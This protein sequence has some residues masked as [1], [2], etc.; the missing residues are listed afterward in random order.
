MPL[1]FDTDREVITSSV[2][3]CWQ[4]RLDR[5]RLCLMPNT[6]EVGELWVSKPLADELAGREGVSVEGGAMELPFDAAG[7]LDQARLFPHSVRG[8]RGTG[9]KSA[10]A[11]PRPDELADAETGWTRSKFPGRGEVLKTPERGWETGACCSP[12]PF[13]GGGRGEGLLGAWFVYNSRHLLTLADRPGEIAMTTPD[14]ELLE[15]LAELRKALPSMR[16]GQLIA[17]MATVARGDV[18]GATW[19]VEDSELL[20]AAKWQLERLSATADRDA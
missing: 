4:P 18:P 20:A 3:T 10:R 14:D 9:E 19:E 2:E 11:T 5:V 17:N 15:V 7:N 8:R 1:S 16:F 6:L 12:S 13:R